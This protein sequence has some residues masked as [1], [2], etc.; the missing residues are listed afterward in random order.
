MEDIVILYLD[1]DGTL[2]MTT[3]RH[4][5]N[6]SY[7]IGHG[8][9]EFLMYA[10]Q[11]YDCR[12]LSFHARLGFINNVS[13]VFREALGVNELRSDWKDV[14]NL[15]QPALW[16]RHKVEAINLC[17]DFLWIDDDVSI[18]CQDVLAANNMTD[19]WVKAH[20]NHFPADLYRL[21]EILELS[22][23]HI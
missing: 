14:I 22:L 7:E 10:T 1:I 20:L 23:I 11:N 12:W 3:E 6:G 8:C 4:H 9:L 13:R 5:Q 19:R 21:R 15:I 18:V 16:R 17:E 2:I